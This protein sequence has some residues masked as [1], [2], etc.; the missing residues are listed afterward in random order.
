MFALEKLN[1]KNGL[2]KLITA[3]T[4]YHIYYENTSL[5]KNAIVRKKYNHRSSKIKIL[6]N[7]QQT[8]KNISF[9]LKFYKFKNEHRLYNI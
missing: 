7:T 5:N 6:S 2:I 8:Q 3:L 4:H 9:Y 1:I